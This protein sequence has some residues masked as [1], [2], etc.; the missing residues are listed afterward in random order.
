LWGQQ[1]IN[2]SHN[3]SS[4]G[5]GIAGGYQAIMFVPTAPDPDVREEDEHE[6]HEHRLPGFYRAG[7][8]FRQDGDSTGKCRQAENWHIGQALSG[9]R[10]VFLA[11]TAFLFDFINPRQ[12]SPT[13]ETWHTGVW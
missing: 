9:L 2:L 6:G 11:E 4:A 5:G 7:S 10:V 12:C 3:A 8:N 13:L 1:L